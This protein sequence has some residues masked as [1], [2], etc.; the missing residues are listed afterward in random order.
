MAIL[1]SIGLFAYRV[2]IF[3]SLVAIYGEVKPKKDTK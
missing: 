2:I 3:L 1:G